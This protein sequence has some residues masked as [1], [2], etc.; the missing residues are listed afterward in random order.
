MADSPVIFKKTKSRAGQRARDDA[1]DQSVPELAQED[2][3]ES[4]IT[5]AS[6]LKTK[7]KRS[8]PKSKLSFGGDDEDGEA[9]SFQIKKSSLSRRLKLGTHPANNLPA[10]LDQAT[11]STRTNG[12]P[13]YDQ[14]YLSELRASTQSTGRPANNEAYDADLSMNV[15]DVADT[16]DASGETVIPSQSSI[17]AAKERRERLR[18]TGAEQDHISLSVTRRG[19][20]SQGPHPESRL[21]RE[22][23]ELGDGDDEYAEYTSAQERI[24]LG[25]KSRKAEAS[26]RK[27]A[28]QEMIADANEE[29]EETMEWERG[30]VRRGGLHSE[31]PTETLP[32][33]QVYKAAPIPSST[34][35]PAL[36]P[37]MERLAQSL[38]TL[39][40][41]HASNT[42]AVA[43]LVDEREQLDVREVELRQLIASAE[44]K[45]SWFTAFKDWIE[46]IATFLDEKY[47]ILE[48]VEEEYISLIRERA[49]MVAQRRHGDDE[50]DLAL[51]FGSFN[52]PSSVDGAESD[53][54]GRS[55]HKGNPSIHRR[56]RRAACVARRAH[57]EA[58]Q[59]LSTTECRDE[60]YSTDS[61][62]GSS[63][64]MDYRSALEK[65]AVNSQ[66][67]LSD[68]RAAD[69][70]EP[71]HGLCKWFGQW[72]ERYTDSYAGAWGGL[73]L[74]GAWEFWVRLDISGWNPLESQKNLEDF[75]WYSSLHQ[76]SLF[77]NGDGDTNEVE[78]SPDGNLISTMV[79]TAVVPRICKMLEAGALDPYSAGG[80]RRMI[81]IAEQVEASIGTDNPKFEAMLKSVHSVFDNA[82][83]AAEHLL[84]PFTKHSSPLFNPEA[85]SARLRLLARASKLL[86]MMTRW[87]KYA[88]EKFGAGK[89]CLRFVS[90]YVLPI[91]ETGWEAGGEEK[92]R[93]IMSILPR[94]LS[95]PIR[96]RL[97]S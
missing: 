7:V 53:E 73:G 60:G 71:T 52:I 66:E 94:E 82:T 81:D 78:F 16:L 29:D 6:K 8:K 21:V 75:S 31:I 89:L 70:R 44:S 26:N 23:D 9:E 95:A 80:I 51:V 57:R 37:A 45:R 18:S 25:R 38:A 96:E 67:I 83:T 54:P 62:L 69:F 65:V 91:A 79:S 22:E 10:T 36:G 3:N 17:L 64:A 13:V 46:S 58:R 43:S 30:Q 87:R 28:M 88:G 15:D 12:A 61:S 4:P 72:R 27:D 11:I 2:D 85:T 34:S 68:V 1:A 14:A 32:M 41:S 49:E 76:Y 39:T 84:A 59:A 20:V 74:V 35:V 86:A 92:V 93:Q 56:E 24:A 63:D 19:D 90:D 33:K 77:P 5:L 97:R 48:K 47:P 40:A 55:S 42:R 50:G